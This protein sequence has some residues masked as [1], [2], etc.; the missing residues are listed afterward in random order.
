MDKVNIDENNSRKIEPFRLRD[1]LK[2][3]SVTITLLISSI[4]IIGPLGYLSGLLYHAVYLESFGLNSSLF[5][6][7]VQ[8]AYL[9]AF[10]VTTT[11]M[12]SAV[13]YF[14]SIEMLIRATTAFFGFFLFAYLLARTTRFYIETTEK[15]SPLHG[16][17]NKYLDRLHY[18]NSNISLALILLWEVFSWV[19]STLF[20][21]FIIILAWMLLISGTSEQAK[22]HADKTLQHYHENGCQFS[23]STKLN[24]CFQIKNSE[25]KTIHKGLLV[26]SSGNK[27]ALYNSEGVS[28]FTLTN[29]DVLTRLRADSTQKKE[30]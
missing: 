15:S 25:H 17:L 20:F 5:S 4:G 18:K 2:E 12:A 11:Y 14:F 28:V 30:I 26:A 27:V 29:A 8:D 1:Y 22:N 24:N 6:L 21:L 3:N 13:S 7:S 19:A 16:T 10:F 23:E 9:Y